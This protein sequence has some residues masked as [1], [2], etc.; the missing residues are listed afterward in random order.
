MAR[1]YRYGG[2]LFCRDRLADNRD[3]FRGLLKEAGGKEAIALK[4]NLALYNLFPP[5][6]EFDRVIAHRVQVY[7]FK[8][9]GWKAAGRTENKKAGNKRTYNLSAPRYETTA[10]RLFTPCGEL[11]ELLDVDF[12][13]ILARGGNL[14]IEEIVKENAEVK[15]PDGCIIRGRK[16]RKVPVPELDAH[17]LHEYIDLKIGD[18]SKSYDFN[19]KFKV[20][21]PGRPWQCCLTDYVKFNDTIISETIEIIRPVFAGINGPEEFSDVTYHKRKGNDFLS[22]F[23]AHF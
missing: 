1:K 22:S 4:R 16:I 20:M 12:G 23:Q 9:L 15:L 14:L 17:K 7:G 10:R 6:K 2:I 19:L 3:Y 21:N 13:A 11:E 5:G 8:E 18:D